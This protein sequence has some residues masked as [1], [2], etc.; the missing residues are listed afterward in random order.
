MIDILCWIICYVII[1]YQIFNGFDYLIGFKN[2]K[3]SS[4]SILNRFYLLHCGLEFFYIRTV[5]TPSA[6]SW[7]LTICSITWKSWMKHSRKVCFLANYI[8]LKINYKDTGHCSSIN[9]TTCKEKAVFF[10]LAYRYINLALFEPKRLF[11][12]SSFYNDFFPEGL[13]YLFRIYL[14]F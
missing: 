4:S 9:L 12:Y 7:L 14:I 2:F 6:K 3:T 11:I 13:W 5:R 10:F 1:Y 8:N